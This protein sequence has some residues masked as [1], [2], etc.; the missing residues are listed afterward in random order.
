MMYQVKSL[1]YSSVEAVS[2]FLTIFYIHY[3]TLLSPNI[4]CSLMS[5]RNGKN[6][7]L[8]WYNRGLHCSRQLKA[9]ITDTFLLSLRFQLDSNF[10]VIDWN[11]TVINFCLSKTDYYVDSMM[12]SISISG[13]SKVHFTGNKLQ[14][15]Y[16]CMWSVLCTC[17]T[18]YFVLYISFR[19]IIRRVPNV[20]PFVEFFP[21][22]R[23]LKRNFQR[24]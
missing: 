21:L 15:H 24:I 17:T 9:L 6:Q 7:I 14:N 8:G 16:P 4:D 12:S 2:K 3:V 19:T 13:S 5:I 1:V 20:T 23:I 11:L 22:Q 18:T 10:I